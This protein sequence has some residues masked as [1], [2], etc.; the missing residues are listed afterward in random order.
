MSDFPLRD[1]QQDAVN[2]VLSNFQDPSIR[3]QLLVLPTGA[4]KTRCMAE[5][6]KYPPKDGYVVIQAHRKELV[7]QI[8]MALAKEKLPH[9]FIAQKPT[10]QFSQREQMEKLGSSYYSPGANI[11]VA[12]AQTLRNKHAER[13]WDDVSMFMS[14][15]AHHWVK[16]TQWG[17]NREKFPNAFGLGPTATP[18]RA[19]GR[20]LGRHA[21]GYADTMVIGPCMRDLINRGH[22][23][24]YRLIMAETD[25]DLTKVMLSSTGDFNSSQLKK[26]MKES[27]IVGDTVDTWKKYAAGM[28]T[29]V[30][31]DSVET[32]EQTAKTFCDAGI[33]AESISSYDSDEDRAAKLKR[34]EKRQTLVLCNMDLFGEGFDCPAVE[35][36]IMDRPTES[37]S[38]FVQQWG[39]ALR[40]VA[41]KTALIID[42]V[43]NVRR[44]LARGFCLPD[45]HYPWTLDSRDRKSKSDPGESNTQCTNKGDKERGIPPCLLPYPSTLKSCPFCGHTPEKTIRGELERV[46]GNLRELTAEELEELRRSVIQIDRDPAAVR[47]NMLKAGAP[48]AAAYSAEKNIRILNEAQGELRKTIGVWAA[49]QKSKG[50]PDSEAYKY[51]YTLFGHDVLSSQSLNGREARELNERIRSTFPV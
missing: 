35:C 13:W 37:Y 9:R 47:A 44:F 48:A 38:L 41:G 42:K 23:S 6:A 2:E 45:D 19:D 33:P 16:G 39:R 29:I 8:A 11:I 22:L 15:E 40:Y 30:F 3:D 4:G 51:F 21:D 28:L 5:V 18:I 43:G 27:S 50:V 46:E 25:L 14:D 34:F 20:G 24:P 12:S 1:Y 17:E 49:Y 26:A 36:V 7:S 32:S 31:T 10:V